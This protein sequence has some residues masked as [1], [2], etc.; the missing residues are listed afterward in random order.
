MKIGLACSRLDQG[1]GGMERLA[2]DIV[3]CM[4]DRGIQPVVITRAVDPGLPVVKRLEK[5][6]VVNVSFI[7]GK[8]RDK[9]FSWRTAKI[10]DRE[11]IDCLVTCHR[12]ERA[13]VPIC[14]GN[15]LGYLKALG[16]EKPNWV[17]RL[18]I[19][20]E[21]RQFCNAKKVVAFSEL[22]EREL[23]ELYGVKPERVKLLYPPVDAGRFK[24]LPAARRSALRK[25]L[26]MEEGKRYFLFP[27][28][29]HVRK[30]LPF[31]RVFF[32]QTDLPVEMLVAG[33]DFAGSRNVRGVGY[34]KDI[35]K[36]YQAADAT[37]MA[38]VYEPFG[39]VGVE[40]VVCGT[41]IVMSRNMACCEA[42][43][44]PALFAF[45]PGDIRGLEASVRGV[46]AFDRY[47]HGDLADCIIYD[48]R[49]DA[50]LD[51]LL[52]LAES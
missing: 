49:T 38:S 29:A 52:K 36:Y 4:L 37:I 30:G 2:H 19:E 18:H 46:M 47:A 34:L 7:P 42:V 41:P 45:E 43:R 5:V 10:R 16:R 31:L 32:E 23:V 15:H 40:S 14:G 26:G 24:A 20:T 48:T 11:G 13:D 12:V 51:E 44:E 1:G 35:E 50:Y 25:E 22:M 3:E 21:R 28:G 27:S 8:L 17:D 9:Y 39:M 6:H 33:K